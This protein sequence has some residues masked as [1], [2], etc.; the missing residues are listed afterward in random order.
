MNYFSAPKLGS[1]S[2]RSEKD[3]RWNCSG[4]GYGLVCS[5]GPPEINEWVA[6]CTDALGPPPDDLMASFVKD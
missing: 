1:W 6:R 4:R 5:G 3:P 2:V